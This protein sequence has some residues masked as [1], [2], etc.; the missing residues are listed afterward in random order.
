MKGL[1]IT[2]LGYLYRGHALFK[3]LNAQ[4]ALGKIIALVGVNGCGKSTL[5]SILA[6]VNQPQQGEVLFNGDNLYQSNQKSQ[7]G[8]LPHLPCLYPHLTVGENLVWLKRLQKCP[9]PFLAVEIFMEKYH[10][11]QFKNKL[12]GKLSDGQKK[13]VNLLTSIM[14]SPSLILLDE[15]CSLL[16]PGQRQDVWTL[17][18]NLRDPNKVILFS[19]HH[20]SEVSHVADEIV[21]LHDGQLHVEKSVR[22]ILSKVPCL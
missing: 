14:H 8:Y 2:D 17:L 15:P 4:F 11:I 3:S 7:I 20:V 1:Q 19:T 13:R 6:G 5:L 10:L 9:A 12:F 22:P 16:D 18:M 21:C